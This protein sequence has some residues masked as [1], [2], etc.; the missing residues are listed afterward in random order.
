MAISLDRHYTL[1]FETTGTLARVPLGGGAPRDDPR[2]R[3]DRRLVARRSEP[4]GQPPGREPLSP[5]VP[6]REDHLRDG[7]LDQL[8]ARLARRA[9]GRL[10]RP[11]AARQQRGRRQGR[12]YGRQ[13]AARGSPGPGRGRLVAARRRGVVARTGR[14]GHDALRKDSHR[15]EL[16]GT[17]ALHDIASDGRLLLGLGSFRREIVGVEAG[18][19]VERNLTWLNWSFPVDIAQRRQDRSLRRAE[20]PPERRVPPD[21]GRRSRHPTRRGKRHEPLGGRPVGID[22]AGGR[23]RPPRPASDRRG[24]AESRWRAATSRCSG[25]S[26]SPTAAAC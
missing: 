13:G 2:G 18:G 14:A 12:G 16:A 17:P 25:P 4:R 15:L 19:K 6:D 10:H 26:G 20:H 9:P 3:R 22:A 11:P 1:G 23:R 7:R 8:R 24:R 21:A 5:R